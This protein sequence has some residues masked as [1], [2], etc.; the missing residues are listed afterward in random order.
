MQTQT[1]VMTPQRPPPLADDTRWAAVQARD[2]GADGRFFYSV[3]T[4][5][6][7]CRPSCGARLPLRENV[8]CGSS[9]SGRW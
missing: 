2:A 4:T 5:G 1:M 6:V 7:Y 8:A 9:S 3:R